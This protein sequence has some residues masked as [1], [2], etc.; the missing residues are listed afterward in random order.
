MHQAWCHGVPAEDLL[1]PRVEVVC[2]AL[3]GLLAV[4]EGVLGIRAKAGELLLNLLGELGIQVGKDV[5]RWVLRL[6][7]D[8][9]AQLGDVTSSPAYQLRPAVITQGSMD[10]TTAFS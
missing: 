10:F 3:E 6:Q 7:D 1:L 9:A 4:G 2:H 8:S 5:R